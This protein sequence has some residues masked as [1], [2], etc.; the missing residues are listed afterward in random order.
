MSALRLTF[1]RE[2]VYLGDSPD[3]GND[4]FHAEW[5]W[6]LTASNGRIVG[7]STESYRKRI[8][9]V[10]NAALVLDVR[11]PDLAADVR[12]Y[13]PADGPIRFFPPARAL[14]IEVQP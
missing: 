8:D 13:R 4:D 11:W 14:D 12:D 1:K 9:A 2:F 3:P 6:T 10:K 5:R 7:A